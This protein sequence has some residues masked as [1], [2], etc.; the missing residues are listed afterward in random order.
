[1]ASGWVSAL[2][3]RRPLDVLYVGPDFSLVHLLAKIVELGGRSAVGWL[4]IVC[5]KLQFPFVVDDCSIESV[6]AYSHYSTQKCALGLIAVAICVAGGCWQEIEYTGPIPSSSPKAVKRTDERPPAADARVDS[7]RYPKA[8]N[9]A[10]ET[11]SKSEPAPLFGDTAN[12]GDVAATSTSQN[13][14]P[15]A[16]V[17]PPAADPARSTRR[18]A[19]LLGAKLSLAAL[20]ND[21]GAPAE[22]T[23]KWISQSQ[24]LAKMLGTSVADLP[25]VEANASAGNP[26][27]GGLNYLFSQGQQIGRDLS[28]GQGDDHAALFELAVKSNILLALYKPNAPIAESLAGAIRQASVRAGLPEELT[29]PLLTALADGESPAD[30]RDAVFKMHADVDH[31]LSTT[32]QPTRLE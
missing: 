6:N 11:T 7:E 9:S 16:P 3:V 15:A 10:P 5:H 19:W 23:A 2:L 1:M 24:A 14:E 17:E 30:V 29:R 32:P 22:E 25:A 28:R 20:G 31:Y 27:E 12:S 18:M 13:E 21:R 8:E 4:V 26:H